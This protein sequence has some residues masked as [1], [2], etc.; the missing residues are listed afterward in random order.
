M[1]KYR[2]KLYTAL[3]ALMTLGLCAGCYLR[4]RDAIPDRVYVVEGEK[5]GFFHVGAAAEHL[6]VDDGEGVR[7]DGDLLGVLRHVFVA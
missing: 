1:R 7:K 6:A 5:D 4:M 2:K 3:L